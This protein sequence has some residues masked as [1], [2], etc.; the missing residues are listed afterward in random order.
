[1][2]AR[3]LLIL[4]TGRENMAVLKPRIRMLD[5]DYMYFNDLRCHAMTATHDWGQTLQLY[6]CTTEDPTGDETTSLNVPVW[7]LI[8]LNPGL[9]TPYIHQST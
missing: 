2:L 9:G 4:E 6:T 5:C 3:S 7:S 8:S 1:M